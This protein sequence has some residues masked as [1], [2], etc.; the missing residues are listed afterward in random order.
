MN[1][2]DNITEIFLII[3]LVPQ[4]FREVILEQLPRKTAVESGQ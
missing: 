1:S 4:L 2:K 3:S